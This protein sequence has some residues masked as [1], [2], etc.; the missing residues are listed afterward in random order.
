MGNACVGT[1]T[2]GTV[3][4]ASNIAGVQYW[5]KVGLY[6]KA[7][8]CVLFHWLP[9]HARSPKML[10]DQKLWHHTQNTEG[11]VGE[12]ERAHFESVIINKQMMLALFCVAIIMKR[13]GDQCVRD[14]SGVVGALVLSTAQ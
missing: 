10:K 4:D 5:N 14:F 1:H 8:L 9:S 7:F 2:V 6:V 11:H 13:I 3:G 12:R